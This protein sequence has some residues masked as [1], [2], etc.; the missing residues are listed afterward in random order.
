MS[1]VKVLK[2]FFEEGELGRKATL[3]EFKALS[4]EER[5]ELAEL[6]AVEIGATVDPIT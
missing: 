2:T 5:Q 3:D 4:A 6:A 1:P